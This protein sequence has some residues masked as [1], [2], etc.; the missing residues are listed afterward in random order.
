[1]TPIDEVLTVARLRADVRAGRVR[2]IREAAGL[3]QDEVARALGVDQASIMRWEKG[4]EPRHEHALKYAD[5]LNRLE[6]EKKLWEMTH[7]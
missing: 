1:M 4:R 5:L 2:A 3:S 6:D 7:P